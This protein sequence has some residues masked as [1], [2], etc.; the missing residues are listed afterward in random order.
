[1]S[2]L[3]GVKRIFCDAEQNPINSNP[4]YPCILTIGQSVGFVLAVE[5][6]FLSFGAV[7]VI[8][9]LI[10]RNLL[11]YRKILPNGD[12]KL[13]RTPADIYMLSLFV[14][15]LL[16]A[17]G[18]IL[19]IRWAHDGI[20]TTGPYCTAQGVIKQIGGTGVALITLILTIHTFMMALWRVGEE[21]RY[22]AFSF[23]ALT[24][25]FIGLWV[26]IG[27]AI[28]KNFEAPTPYWCWIGP[29]YKMERI[30]GEY[31]WLW[32]ALFASVVMY[33]PVHFWMK[34]QL[35]VDNEKWYKFRLAK[36]DIESSQR[37]ATWGILF[38]PLAYSLIVIPLS[39][40]RWLQFDH[41]TV[42]PAAIFFGQIMFNLSGAVNVLLF[43]IVR[44][45]LLL[46]TPPEKLVEPEVELANPSTGPA[47]FLD[48][49]TLSP[50]TMEAELEL[51][52]DA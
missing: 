5:A 45:H 27:N 6:S 37:R 42:P 43:L 13:L 2:A 38:Y 23:V 9:M 1:M 47:L 26:G 31:L 17:I 19:D 4:V 12:W 18:D 41:K 10:V 14:Y 36:T 7:I 44:P 24:W 28:H 8:F 49:Y 30:A 32:I 39:I 51:V 3:D 11:R 50:Q 15:D 35:S 52:N 20:V 22:F 34:G 40:S 29:N 33:V 46:F 16:L 48:V 21:A 25:L